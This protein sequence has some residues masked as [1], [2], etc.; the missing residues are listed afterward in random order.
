MRLEPEYV[1]TRK[2]MGSLFF[3][4]AFLK[5]DENVMLL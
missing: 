4:I 1:V 2:Q 3:L 5:K